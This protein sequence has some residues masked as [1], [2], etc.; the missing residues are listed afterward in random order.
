MKMK[1]SLQLIFLL[2]LSWNLQEAKA[3]WV[4]KDNT[5]IKVS[6]G[7]YINVHGDWKNNNSELDLGEGTIKFSGADN[8]SIEGTNTF[9][10]MLVEKYS[11]EL[12]LN[13]NLNCNGSLEILYGTFNVNPEIELTLNNEFTNY[14]NFIIKSDENGT[15]S[16]LDNGIISGYG[17][18]TVEQYLTGGEDV[19]HYVS[20]QAEGVL[21]EIFAGGMLWKYNET[22]SNFEPIV[23]PYE[24]LSGLQGYAASLMENTTINYTGNLFSGTKTITG[25]T[26][27]ENSSP[28]YDG[29]NLVGNPFPSL[30]DIESPGVTLTNLGNAFY[31]WDNT[32]NGG[33]GDFSIYLKGGSNIN[34]ATQY[35]RGGQ[36]FFLK[37]D[38]P[39]N[40]GTFSLDNSARLHHA[41][42]GYNYPEIN[43]LRLSA[44]GGVFSDETI[45]C[46]NENAT[47]SFDSEFDAYKFILNNN[48]NQLFSKTSEEFGLAINTLP[49]ILLDNGISVPLSYNIV[50]SGNY[51][52]TASE[53]ESFIEANII[54]E[55][56]LLGTTINLNETP[57]YNFTA[58]PEDDPDRFIVHFNV[59]S[60]QTQ[61]YFLQEGYQFISTRLIPE[62]QNM[63]SV[64][65]ENLESL[66]F[67]R[68]TAG[69]MLRKIGPMWV[70]GIG[71]WV[72]T[73]GYLFKM[74]SD[75]ELTISGEAIDPQTPI[76]LINGYQ[77]ISF[78]PEFPVNTN[79]AFADVLDNLDFVRNTTGLMFRK[80][81]P[82]WVNGIGDMQPGEG[83]LVKMSAD[84]L[85]IYPEASDNFMALKT[86]IP[87]HFKVIDGNPYD[88][89]W[90]IYFEQG[91]LNIGDEIGVFDEETL[92]GAG[93]VIS[94][95]IFEN[96]IPVF[97]NL[98]EN[99]NY[100]IF[101][102]W[103]KNGQEEVLLADYIYIN[104]Y[105]SAYMEETFPE[106][107][108][109]YSMLNFSITGISDNDINY[110]SLTIYPNP[111]DGIFNIS[112][113]KVRGDLQC[114]VFDLTGNEYRNVEFTGITGFTTKQINLQDLPAGVY[115]ISF[116]GRSLSKVEKIVIN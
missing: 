54:L 15:G 42:P 10:N 1:I 38:S 41:E 50:E 9:N 77:M 62:N 31:F 86:S 17:I 19:W 80:I 8:Q 107:D 43:F 79:D 90:T 47:Q 58:N 67:V 81:G 98:Y 112:L 27:T 30:I 63:M 29:F 22:I 32:L 71:N 14:G 88:P 25:L 74:N 13:G 115:F 49:N 84:D 53:M 20:P 56:V 12:E 106:I 35:I 94:E 5:T 64:L 11:N 70:N 72:T 99:G 101:K 45:I 26:Y 89:V 39:G 6:T 18:F 103:S 87:E 52:I 40:I 28:N 44:E 16:L 111:S 102:I 68:N 113:E 61:D 60:T 23:D 82:I 116:T 78:L 110:S 2:M 51:T 114:K 75:D 100:P 46:F 109:E 73:E 96:S 83:Y 57:I 37:V 85:L 34:G 93:I 65:S 3:Q 7:S 24:P 69:L 36:G 48:V 59:S 105:G 108:G 21:S 76:D 97:S 4:T 95:N 91:A 66:D 104:P 55:D 33:L 92:V